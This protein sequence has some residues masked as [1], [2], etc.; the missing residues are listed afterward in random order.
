MKHR[1]SLLIRGYEVPNPYP[2]VL[3]THCLL[4]LG[5]ALAL[6]SAHHYLGAAVAF[7]LG[8]GFFHLRN[9]VVRGE[10]TRGL[11]QPA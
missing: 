9:V 8:L 1:R 6:G 11:H 7:T 4:T 5:P 2:D 10:N 3:A